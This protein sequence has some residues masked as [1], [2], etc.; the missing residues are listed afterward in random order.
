MLLAILK[1][2]FM[3]PTEEFSWICV[4]TRSTGC[5]TVAETMPEAPPMKKFLK[6][7]GFLCG[8]LEVK[9]M[10]YFQNKIYLY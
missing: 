4:L 3:R 6:T 9:D 10:F 7:V 5:I 1:G 2:F 8:F